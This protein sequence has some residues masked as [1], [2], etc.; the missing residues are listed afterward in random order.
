LV[1]RQAVFVFHTFLLQLLSHLFFE[2]LSQFLAS[3]AAVLCVFD[4]PP[5]CVQGE[6]G[7]GSDGSGGE[8][9]GGSSSDGEEYG[10][11]DDSEDADV[12][13]AEEMES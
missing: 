12:K 11:G 4:P 7:S 5:R 6:G 13:Y 9:E 8:E 2:P 3:A 1:C 10:A